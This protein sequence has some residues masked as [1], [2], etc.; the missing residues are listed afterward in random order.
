[1][2][3]TKPREMCMAYGAGGALSKQGRC[4]TFEMRSSID[5]SF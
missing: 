3:D 4:Q 1:M 5:D 2:R